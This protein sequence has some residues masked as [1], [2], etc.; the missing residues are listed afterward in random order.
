MMY[1][2]WQDGYGWAMLTV[3]VLFWLLVVG[4]ITLVVLALMRAE[5]R[6]PDDRGDDTTQALSILKERFARGEIDDDEF[7][8]RHDLLLR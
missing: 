2:H 5:G 8:R 1:W 6:R 3:N 7:R 4:G